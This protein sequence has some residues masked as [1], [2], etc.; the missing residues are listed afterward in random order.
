[1]DVI[2][3][4]IVVA[5]GQG[6]GHPQM[7]H[8]QATHTPLLLTHGDT[9]VGAAVVAIASHRSAMLAPF[10]F[11]TQHC[12]HALRRWRRS[13]SSAKGDGR[14][15]GKAAAPQQ[16]GRRNGAGGGHGVAAHGSSAAELAQHHAVTGGWH[17]SGLPGA[18]AHMDGAAANASSPLYGAPSGDNIIEDANGH[19]GGH[20]PAAG[21]KWHAGVAASEA[22]RQGSKTLRF[23]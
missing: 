7:S 6:P 16:H 19:D 11:A 14:A 15:P 22:G 9:S 5:A 2:R 21:S 4:M 20:L 12:A 10:T 3:L 17:D 23:F 8:V 13:G 1:M 18:P